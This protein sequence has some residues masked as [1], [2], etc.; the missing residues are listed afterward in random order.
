MSKYTYSIKAKHE[1]IIWSVANRNGKEYHV[2]RHKGLSIGL[3]ILLF[4]GEELEGADA[5][6]GSK[7]SH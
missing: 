3:Q 1:R 6:G 5:L 7:A 2:H 4:S